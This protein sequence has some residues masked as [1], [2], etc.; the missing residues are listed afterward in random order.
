MT[1]VA[2]QHI[3][4]LIEFTC[5]GGALV[6]VGTAIPWLINPIG[7][8]NHVA[9]AW[10]RLC[11]VLVI[12]VTIRGWRPRGFGLALTKHGLLWKN[13]WTASVQFTPW[14]DIAGCELIRWSDDDGDESLGLLVGLSDAAEHPFGPKVGKFL[15]DALNERFGPLRW[16][17]V[18]PLH[19]HKWLW[20]VAEV[21]EQVE[22][23]LADLAVREAW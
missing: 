11:G 6:A 19:H 20:N 1:V 14:G 18:I 22:R 16:S 15:F 3:S 21:C 12:W 7:W 13:Q 17:R 9:G 8:W 2:R 4:A 10:F 23:S 5:V